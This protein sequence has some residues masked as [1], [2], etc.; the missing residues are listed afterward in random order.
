VGVVDV[1]RERARRR[2]AERMARI[3]PA[4]ATAR[5]MSS[6]RVELSSDDSHAPV[7]RITSAK[8]S[9]PG[10]SWMTQLLAQCS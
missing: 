4:W 9:P 10:A 2:Q 1:Q 5:T 6:S 7:R 8:L 3:E